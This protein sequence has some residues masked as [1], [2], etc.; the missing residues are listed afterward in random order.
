[1]FTGQTQLERFIN[2]G[3]NI[4]LDN[5]IEFTTLTNQEFLKR[6]GMINLDEFNVMGK[7]RKV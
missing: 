2:Y 4:E 3:S 1:M 5:N 6:T 7:V